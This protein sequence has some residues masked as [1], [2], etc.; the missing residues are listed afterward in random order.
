VR[1]PHPGEVRLASVDPTAG[2]NS[3]WPPRCSVLPRRHP[4]CSVKTNGLAI[5]E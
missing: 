3:A 5:H 2:A 1:N 4:D